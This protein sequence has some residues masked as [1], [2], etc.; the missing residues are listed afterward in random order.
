[1]LRS[2]LTAIA[3]AL[4]EQVDPAMHEIAQQVEADAQSRVPVDTGDLRDAIHI[5]KVDEGA[6]AVVAGDDDAFYGHM[7]ENGTTHSPPRPFLI[8]AAEAVRDK[9]DDA[10]RRALRD[11]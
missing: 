11:L 1:M 5:V 9:V 3:A 2:R 4:D 6:Y 10:V 7:V 8:P